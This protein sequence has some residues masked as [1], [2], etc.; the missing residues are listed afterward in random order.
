MKKKQNARK[1]SHGKKKKGRSGSSVQGAKK[2]GKE[3]KENEG[4]LSMKDLVV[5]EAKSVKSTHRAST[6]GKS[7]RNADKSLDK[8]LRDQKN[9]L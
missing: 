6:A 3:A 9:L 5:V 2:A 1:E 8:E 4:P 7:Q